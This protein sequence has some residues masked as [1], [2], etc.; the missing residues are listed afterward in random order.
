MTL[1][2]DVSLPAAA[3]ASI[4][5]IIG[6][7][8][9]SFMA[10]GDPSTGR[11]AFAWGID[12]EQVVDLEQ[13]M[14][15]VWSP[16]ELSRGEGPDRSIELSIEDVALV[17]QGMAFTEV[18]SA[19]LPWVDMVRWTSDFVTAELR[20]HWSDDEWSSFNGS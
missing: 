8:L 9:D 1:E 19:D 15:D 18:M 7:M 2:R 5:Q 17:L 16:E 11:G 20:Q 12:I 3:A 6:M 14:R 4:E 13:R 10:G